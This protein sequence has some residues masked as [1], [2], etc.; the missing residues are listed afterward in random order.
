MQ[1]F[2]AGSEVAP[3]VGTVPPRSDAFLKSDAFP[4]LGSGE[5]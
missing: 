4:V 3:L 1:S 2:L 5:G